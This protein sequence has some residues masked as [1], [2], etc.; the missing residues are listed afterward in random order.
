MT[1]LM[2]L[3]ALQ[4]NATSL[5]SFGDCLELHIRS[6]ECL[7]QTQEMYRAL[8]IPVVINK[9]LTKI[10][11]NIAREHDGDNFTL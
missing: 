8:L 5:R 7:G 6:L 10:R 11:K 2:D 4:N 3:P 1:A 9:L